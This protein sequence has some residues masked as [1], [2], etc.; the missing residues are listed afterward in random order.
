VIVGSPARRASRFALFLPAR[1][2]PRCAARFAPAASQ[3]KPRYLE[4][5]IPNYLLPTLRQTPSSRAM[6]RMQ[7]RTAAPAR[8]EHDAIRLNRALFS[9]F[10]IAHRLLRKTGTRFFALGSMVEAALII[11]CRRRRLK[12]IRRGPVVPEPR[13]R[14]KNCDL[15]RK[16]TAASRRILDRRR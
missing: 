2:A 10:L 8:L 9:K 12:Q 3:G 13:L 16:L 5:G 1:S 7:E 11:R 4:L 14:S 6:G 15:N